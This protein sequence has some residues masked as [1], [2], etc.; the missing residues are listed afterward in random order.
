M[1][2]MVALAAGI[3]GMPGWV[4]SIAKIAIGGVVLV[5]VLNFFLSSGGPKDRD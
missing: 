5:A 4:V 3:E 2:H 1:T